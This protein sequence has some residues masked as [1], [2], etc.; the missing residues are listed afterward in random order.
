[1][2]SLSKVT[3]IF[4]KVNNQFWKA[5]AKYI[6]YY[7]KLPIDE[8]VILLQSQSATKIDGNIYGILRYLT[9]DDKYAGYKIYLSIMGRYKNKTINQLETAGINNVEVV[10]LSSDQYVRLLASAK[11][12]FN[13]TS[14]PSYFIKKEGQIYCNTWHGTPLKAMGVKNNDDVSFGNVQK[15]LSSADY[16]L[17]PNKF[18]KEIMLRD[19]MLEDITDGSYVY[20]GYPRN[21]VF[22]D[23]EKR[24]QVREEFD[25]VGKKVYAYMPTWR[26]TVD[27]VGI[28]KNDSYLTVY[29]YQLDKLL[30]DDEILY[31]NLHPMAVHAKNIIKI[32]SD[33]KHIRNFPEGI[34]TYDFLNVADVLV[35]DYSSVFFDFANTRQK[36]VL[37]PYDKEDYLADR[38]MYMDMDELPFPQAFNPEELIKELRAPKNYDDSEF[39]KTF[40]EY[41]NVNAS[42]QLC[43]MVVLGDKSE[44]K[45]EKI[46][47]NGKENVLIYEGSLA[48]NG[49]ISSLRG[50]L[51]Q[52]DTTKRNYYV[53]FFQKGAKNNGFQL[54]T[55]DENVKFLSIADNFDLTIFE[56]IVRGLF[57]KGII[58]NS[59]YMKIMKKRFAQNFYRAVGGAKFDKVINY[60]GYGNEKINL[61]SQSPCSNA[62]WVHSDMKNEIKFKKNQRNDV[63][64]YA[65]KN[66]DKVI[67]ASSDL[68]PCVE[69]LSSNKADI[70]NIPNIIDYKSIIEKASLPIEFEDKTFCSVEQDKFMEII[71]SDAIK[72]MNLGKLSIEKGQERLIDAFYRL[73]KKNNEMYLIILGG[74]S[75][76]GHKDK[77]LEKITELGLE[78]NVILITSMLNPYPVIKACDYFV[79][80][81]FYEGSGLALAEASVLSKPCIA[82]DVV[83]VRSFI[84]TYGG[85]IVENSEN[86]IYKGMMS[87]VEGKISPMNIDYDKHNSQSA[88]AFESIF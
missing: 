38:G 36:I 21:E 58:R 12:L 69:K 50:L 31:V 42:Q 59:L 82:T 86:G 3:K 18:T 67:T 41:D 72:F 70:I 52:I 32:G 26:G 10:I 1:M 44:L 47:G 49:I 87:L 8:N 66:Y 74:Y 73:W 33:L 62:I 17:Y 46:V 4:N 80:S 77:L 16:L 63:L 2:S 13:D 56:K 5:K 64:K 35:T 28:P 65:Y 27:K 88:S 19:Y 23:K 83:G 15:N 25:L 22:F 20:G 37:F 61:F 34:E 6:K 85:T 75:T 7:E 53:S 78:E 24:Q 57:D 30:N 51:N 14:F 9:S 29:I 68:I 55:F 45:A 11:Y 84:E 48:K 71:N 43:D 76:N 39:L 60:N 54:R 79:L 81:S 40:C